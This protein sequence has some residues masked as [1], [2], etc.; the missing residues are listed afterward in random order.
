MCLPEALQATVPDI[1]IITRPRDLDALQL[2]WKG[3]VGG[4]FQ[5]IPLL[6]AVFFLSLQ[7]GRSRLRCQAWARCL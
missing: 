3:G 1:K 5:E 6:I 4:L 7:A 2:A